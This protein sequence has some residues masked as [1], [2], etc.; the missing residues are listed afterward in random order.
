MRTRSELPKVGQAIP[1][2]PVRLV[3][4][5]KVGIA[6]VVTILEITKVGK[7][8]TERTTKNIIPSAKKE[9]RPLTEAFGGPN[10]GIVCLVE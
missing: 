9:G 7:M 5:D 4:R 6:T 10:G 2:L 8:P 1:E 3:V